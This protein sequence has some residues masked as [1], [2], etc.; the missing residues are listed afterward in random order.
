M[1]SFSI[2]LRFSMLIF[3]LKGIL[4]PL[5]VTQIGQ[6]FFYN[7]ATGR[8]IYKNDILVGAD[9]IGQQFFSPQ[10]FHS[11]NDDSISYRDGIMGKTK[12]LPL[13][14]KKLQQDI[15]NKYQ[16]YKNNEIISLPVELVTDSASGVDP[17]I[18]RLSAIWQIPRIAKI[19]N[20]PISIVEEVVYSAPSTRQFGFL[21]QDAVNVLRL[22]LMLD[23]IL[24]TTQ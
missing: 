19:R 3:L 9:L 11:R 4:Y 10:Y 15:I 14:T 24:I 1:K 23:N 22:N 2:L 13:Y 18:T 8:L 12:A 5:V 17:H 20:I 6:L 16:I 7:N 21:G